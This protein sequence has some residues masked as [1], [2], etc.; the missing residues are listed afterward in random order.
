MKF[1]ACSVLLFVNVK[2]APTLTLTQM[3]RITNGTREWTFSSSRN[4]FIHK[5]VFSSLQQ[6]TKLSFTLIR[7]II[8]HFY[9]LVRLEKVKSVK[10]DGNGGALRS[11]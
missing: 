10:V 11:I 6:L 3:Q 7:P 5:S 1:K 8:V 2:E 4:T 9:I